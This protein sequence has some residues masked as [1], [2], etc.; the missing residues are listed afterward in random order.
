MRAG[1]AGGASISGD[2]VTV[3]GNACAA[4]IPSALLHHFFHRRKLDA[5]AGSPP[6]VTT[7]GP[8]APRDPALDR[9]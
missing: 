9:V 1:E 8:L 2:A 7:T 6:T 3:T 4:D 5:V